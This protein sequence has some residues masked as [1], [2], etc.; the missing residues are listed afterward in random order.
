M[1]GIKLG[2]VWYGDGVAGVGG[3]DGGV[4]G[5][6]GVDA[7]LDGGGPAAEAEDQVAEGF[8]FCE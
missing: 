3:L 8:V 4:G 7:V 2:G 6:D 5:Q 1:L